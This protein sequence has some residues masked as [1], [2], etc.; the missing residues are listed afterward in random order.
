MIYLVIAGFGIAAFIIVYLYQLIIASKISLPE[1]IIFL[2]VLSGIITTLSYIRLQYIESTSLEARVL[3]PIASPIERSAELI[4]SVRESQK[5]EKI[6][7]PQVKN[8]QGDY[9]VVI[10]NLKTNEYYSLNEKEVYSSASLYKLWTMGT[11]FQQVKDGKLNLNKTLSASIPSLNAAFDLG[12]EA[13]ASEGAITETVNDAL[14]Q[15]ITI[16]H[17]YSAMLLTV[18]VKNANVQKF[19]DDNGFSESKTGVPPKTT[20]EDIAKY[21]EKLYRGRLVSKEASSQMLEILKRQQINDR[22][23]QYLPDEIDV[24]HKTGEL[25]TVKH[26]AGIVYSTHGDYI[27][28]LMSDTNDMDHAA[29]IEAKISKSVWDYFNK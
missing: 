16:S 2:F 11:V 8:E 4:N 7:L 18:A 20:P 29:E 12:D 23:P 14:E 17:N 22:I 5:L 19:L 6:V 15:M 27:I 10:K 1:K 26:D 3:Q 25:Y 13:E 24:A 21:Y 28:V 9:S